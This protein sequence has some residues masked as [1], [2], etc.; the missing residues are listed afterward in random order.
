MINIQ[1]MKQ[2]TP[3]GGV[4]AYRRTVISQ[5]RLGTSARSLTRPEMN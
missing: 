4:A 3:T 1:A 2:T 5:I